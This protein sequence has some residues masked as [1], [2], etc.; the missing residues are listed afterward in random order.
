MCQ[1]HAHDGETH[2][3]AHAGHDYEHV[4][5]DQEHEGGSRAHPHVHEAGLEDVHENKPM[6][7]PDVRDRRPELA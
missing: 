7:A 2:S 3:H 6:T 1:E 5:Y 4:E